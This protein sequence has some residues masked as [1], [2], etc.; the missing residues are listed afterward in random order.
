MSSNELDAQARAVR[1]SPRRLNSRPHSGVR[2]RRTPS[3]RSGRVSGMR[4]GLTGTPRTLW[5][6]GPAS[7]CQPEQRG[8]PP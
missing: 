2:R 5:L 1:H 3:T 7:R 4:P 8:T 6:S